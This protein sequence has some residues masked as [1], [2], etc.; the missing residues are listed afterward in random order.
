MCILQR[1]EDVE[2]HVD[3]QRMGQYRH[4]ADVRSQV[5]IPLV[6]QH[7]AQRAGLDERGCHVERL[8]SFVNDDAVERQ[9][10][11]VVGTTEDHALA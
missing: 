5:R 6:E 3:H 2:E 11:R 4:A 8:A 10:V 7:V 9:N 1:E